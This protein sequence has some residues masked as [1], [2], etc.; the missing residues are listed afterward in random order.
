LVRLGT[1]SFLKELKTLPGIE[2]VTITTN[3]LLLGKFLDETVSFLPDGVN[4]SLDALNEERFRRITRSESATPQG[5]IPHIDR[6]LD[7]KVPVKINCVPVRF[8]NE[9][10]IVPLAALAKSRNVAVRFIELMPLGSAAS[11]EP[12]SG[13][14]TAELLEKAFGKL[15]S[16]SGVEGNGPAVYYSLPGFAG[17]V[18]FINPVSKGF[19][20]TC[21]RLRLSSEGL[22]KPCLSDSLALDLRVLLRGGAPDKVI[23][24]S[25][26]ETAAQKKGHHTLSPVYGASPEIIE[27]KHEAGMYSIGG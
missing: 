4:I 12:V 22:L 23:A 7:M 3:G 27:G 16:F 15:S 25:I 19:C 6:L 18:G 8:I 17:K 2:K 11:F 13:G 20:S 9:E 1:A 10:E 5:I 14:E 24:A 26:V 21:N